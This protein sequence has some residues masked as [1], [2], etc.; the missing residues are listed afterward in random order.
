MLQL[1]LLHTVGQIILRYEQT[2]YVQKGKKIS[3]Q[4]KLSV[5]QQ[6]T[7]TTFEQ[8]TKL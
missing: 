2:V 1:L 8:S 5:V 3:Q 7:A 6:L 4:N